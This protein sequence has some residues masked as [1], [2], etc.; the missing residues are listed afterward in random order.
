[1]KKVFSILFALVV[2]CVVTNAMADG[3]V[4]AP[5]V[6]Q[7]AVMQAKTVQ[8]GSPQTAVGVQVRFSP[9]IEPVVTVVQPGE[10]K[11]EIVKPVTVQTADGAP[12]RVVGATDIYAPR[13]IPVTITEAPEHPSWCVR[14]LGW[15]A[16]GIGVLAGA[17]ALALDAAGAFDQEVSFK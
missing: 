2:L 6:D 4:P 10:M 16:L 8:A 3:G 17:S 14:N 7:P 1:M 9:K 5:A 15:C 13:G 11:A 12:L